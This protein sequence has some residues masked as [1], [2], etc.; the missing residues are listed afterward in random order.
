V[1]AVGAAIHSATMHAYMHA[2]ER[3]GERAS[4]RAG[5]RVSAY[6]LLGAV[7]AGLPAVRFSQELNKGVGWLGGVCEK[8]FGD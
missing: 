3:V 6:R 8:G 2:C 5:E 1:P 4:G 7:W